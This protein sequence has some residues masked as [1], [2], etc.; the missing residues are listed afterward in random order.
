MS[1]EEMCR[2]T[3]YIL[4][5]EIIFDKTLCVGNSLSLVNLNFQ[6]SEIIGDLYFQ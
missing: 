3:H 2:L 1:A 6:I 5:S 4:I